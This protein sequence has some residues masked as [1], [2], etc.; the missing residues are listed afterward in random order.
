MCSSGLT[1]RAGGQETRKGHSDL[2]SGHC[3][4]LITILYYSTVQDMLGRTGGRIT[5]AKVMPHLNTR[6]SKDGQ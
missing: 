4:V 3:S 2:W 1:V 5:R 6:G